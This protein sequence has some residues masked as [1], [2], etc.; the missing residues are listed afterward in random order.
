MAVSSIFDLQSKLHIYQ[1]GLQMRLII[2]FF[3]LAVRWKT[4]IAA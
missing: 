4:Q 3:L 2:I 1:V